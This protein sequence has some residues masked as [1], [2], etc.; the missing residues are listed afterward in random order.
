[1][2][3]RPTGPC[4]AKIMIVGECPGE[5]EVAE[6]APFV[7]MAGQEL[8]R[9]LQE[10]GI[11]R[12]ACFITN[13]VRIRPPGNDIGAFIAERKS[14]I[15]AQ[16]I[17]LRDKFVLPAVRDG[18]ELL[19]REIEMCQPNVIIAF[20]N[21]ALWA[22]TGQWGI[23]SWR[24]S[25][26]ECDLQLSLDYAPKVVP[27]YHPAMILRQ[28]SWRQIAVHDIRRAA[29]QS[30]F[31]EIIRPDYSFVIRPDY[32]TVLTIL[33]QLYQQVQ[34]RPGKLAIDIETRAGHIACIGIAWSEREAL[35]IPLMCVERPDGYWPIEQESTIIFALYQLLTHPN[36]EGVGQNFSYDAQYI[37]RFWH[38]IP[39]I[40]RDTMLAQ[41]SCFAN[42]Q[43]GLDFLSSMYCEHHLYWKGEGKEWDPKKHS[44]DQ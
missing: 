5:R 12:S 10:A 15:S 14:D 41:H 21:V 42:M 9:M 1:M 4:P 44:E 40:K 30:K 38:F 7:G 25:V 43:K 34:S 2:Q 26:M 24:G 17:M 8:S 20:G 28:W 3:I 27:A 39:N 19:K 22:L 36:C 13:V 35:C 31:R 23:T 16:H 11:M 18:F 6:G 37:F 29:A 32:S 33:A